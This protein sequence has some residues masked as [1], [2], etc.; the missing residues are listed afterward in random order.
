MTPYYTDRVV[1]LNATLQ[2]VVALYA[3][4]FSRIYGIQM[5]EPAKKSNLSIFSTSDEQI[6]VLGWLRIF[7]DDLAELSSVL[8]NLLALERH[9][10]LDKINERL[11]R[12]PEFWQTMLLA[13]QTNLLVVVGRLYDPGRRTALKSIVKFAGA[14]KQL[15]DVTEGFNGVAK[16]HA[17]L[18]EKVS[19]LRNNVFAHSSETRKLHIAFGFEGVTGDELE[20]F[21]GELISLADALAVTIFERRNF[22]P[23]L[24][25]DQL[26]DDIA[27]ASEVWSALIKET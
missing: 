7:T 14:R 17:S 11:N 15:S 2:T 22:G 10:D 25:L 19:A 21:C 6:E 9:P 18:I 23:R 3:W 16:K 24:R 5:D 8:G 27:Q 26:H 1:S 20:A 13:L 12:H 4:V